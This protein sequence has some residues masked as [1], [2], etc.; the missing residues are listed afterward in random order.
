MP[1]QNVNAMQLYDAQKC[2]K[3]SLHNIYLKY[4]KVFENT[5]TELLS[6]AEDNLNI[7]KYCLV[8]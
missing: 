5:R 3:N 8:H 1:I 7:A 6:N 2:L 4:I